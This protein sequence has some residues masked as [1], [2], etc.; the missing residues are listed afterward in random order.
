MSTTPGSVIF[1]ATD[2]SERADEAL[3]QASQRARE[4]SS[5]LVVCHVMPNPLLVNMVFPQRHVAQL[6]ARTELHHDARAAVVERMRSVTG[7][8]E[9]EFEVLLDEGTPYSTIV[10]RAEQANAE[11]IV[12]GDRGASGLSRIVLGSVAERVVRHAH[13]TVLI[14]R[15][16]A[17]TGR[18]LVATDLSDPSLPAIA[19][20]AREASREGVHVTL[21]HCVE[22]IN[23]VTMPEFRLAWSAAVLPSAIDE[24]QRIATQKLGEA[25]ERFSVAG[26]RRVAVGSPAAEI[27]TA[28]EQLGAEL[29]VVATHGR[30]GLKRMLLGSVAESVVRH[31][32]CSVLVV[33]LPDKHEGSEPASNL[34]PRET[35]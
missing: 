23:I 30:T 10:A 21:L 9:S 6:E 25:A 35:R 13:T 26:E 2:L 18:V 3:R 32:G 5:T 16:T 20:G 22:P 1:V 12:V 11:L 19:A 7:R 4:S 15:A 14:A 28:A 27:V 34:D 33:R 29:I 24:V 31:A 8:G 17:Q